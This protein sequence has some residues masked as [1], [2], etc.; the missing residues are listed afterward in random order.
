MNLTLFFLLALS[1]FSVTVFGI[2]YLTNI[3]NPKN[4]SETTEKETSETT[5]KETSETTKKY[6][7]N[8]I[9]Y[10]G[11]EMEIEYSTK[12]LIDSNL[13]IDGRRLDDFVLES[14]TANETVFLVVDG[15]VLNL[16]N[17]NITKLG[18]SNVEYEKTNETDRPMKQ[19]F[20]E[21]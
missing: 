20:T 1:L 8:F 18:D 15:G 3:I 16:R 11:E 14:S 2:N 21:I 7:Y 12:N 19:I 9:N 4:S 10:E 17:V 6:K 13:T 5:E